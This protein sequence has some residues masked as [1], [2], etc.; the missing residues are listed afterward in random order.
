MSRQ[1]L[2]DAVNSYLWDQYE[3]KETIDATYVG[4]LEQG[5]YRWPGRLRREAFRHVLGATSSTDLGFYPKRGK[6]ASELESDVTS[7]RLSE[8]ATSWQRGDIDRRA[9]LRSSLIATAW[10]IPDAAVSHDDLQRIVAALQD[11]RRYLDTTVIGHLSRSLNRCAADD[12]IRGPRAALPGVLGVLGV[13]EHRAT[14]VKAQVRREL[15][16]V[17]A[18]AAEF[19]GWL[20][21]DAGMPLAADHWRDRA[22]EWAIESGDFAMP[23]YVLIKKSQSAWDARDALRMLT[24]AQ[25]VQQG[26]W[27]LPARVRAEALQQEARGQAMI[28][29]HVRQAQ[30]KLD[31]ARELMGSERRRDGAADSELA[32]HYDA[33]L[34]EVQMAMCF[35]E[36]GQAE[37]AVMIY[38]SSLSPQVFSRR[39]YAYF[40]TQ[41]AQALA[42]SRR[43]DDAAQAGRTALPIATGAGSRRTA[44]ELVRL[45]DGLRPWADRPAVRAF[46]E[47]VAA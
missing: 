14:D 45:S 33:S 3:I 21:R 8:V 36:G 35:A 43:P 32:A 46:R 16:A 30:G 13:V 42:A 39:D 27:T 25:A 38:E 11:S 44:A 10:M 19:A 40:L 20:Y 12:G 6:R 23:G 41:K 18:R 28:D 2:A 31:Q 24:L 5:R 47:L 29:G 9:L 15:L 37:R 34:F 26:P 17:G 22:S 1:E 7:G 4:H